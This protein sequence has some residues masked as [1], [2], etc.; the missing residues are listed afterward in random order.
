MFFQIRSTL[1][2]K[3]FFSYLAVILAGAAAL[4]TAAELAIPTAFQRHM[5][6]MSEMMGRMNQNMGSNLTTS[7]FTNFR[8]AVREALYWAALAALAA[9]GLVSYLISRWITRPVQEMM[10]ASRHIAEGNYQERVSIPGS[11]RSADELAQLAYSFNQMAEQLEETE[12]LRRQLISDVTHELRTPLTSIQGYAEGLE[13]GVLPEVPETYQHIHREAERLSHLVEDLQ[14]LSRVEAKAFTLDREPIPAQ[15]LLETVRS[16]TAIQFQEKGIELQI[17]YPEGLPHLLADPRRMEQVLLNLIDNALQYTPSGGK[18]ELTV[19]P[20]TDVLEFVIRDT[21]MGIPPEHLPHLFTRFYRVDKSR[22]RTSGG[23]GI[24]LT[25]AK[26]LVE[27][28]GGEIK[29]E[30]AGSGQGST[31][32]FTVPTV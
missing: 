22:A 2:W 19:H 11:S 16:R 24:G 1:G 27:A 13:D 14:Q 4:L 9:A 21:G 5:A 3:L 12:K 7:L 18:V 30:S 15:E 17:L 29:A 8:F 32:R 28:H 23:S 31:F 25:I 6:G 20:K 26:H 10:T